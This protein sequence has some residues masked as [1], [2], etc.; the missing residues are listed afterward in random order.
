VRIGV[1]GS[2]ASG[3]GTVCAFFEE[4][5]GV[6]I[7]TDLIAREVV[8]PGSAALAEIAATFGERFIAAEGNLDRRALASEVFPDAAKTERLNAILHPRILDITLNRSS[9]TQSIY[10][11]NAPLLF[12]SGY[13]A[14]MDATILVTARTEQSVER[15][16]K[17]DNLD[18]EA[19]SERLNRQFSVNKK[20]ELADYE[21]DNSGELS[22]TKRQVEKL[23][24]ILENRSMK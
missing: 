3:K 13:D 2:Y 17:R 22:E 24:K 18:K 11:I 5:G 20:R 1:T 12:E 4:L 15:G 23:W 19:I 21:I 16:K 9:D 7:D 14:Y 6:I 10:F 8:A